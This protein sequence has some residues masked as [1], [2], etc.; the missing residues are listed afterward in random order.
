M[1]Y[2]KHSGIGTD[3]VITKKV[4]SVNSNGIIAFWS[5]VLRNFLFFEWNMLE[6][7]ASGMLLVVAIIKVIEPLFVSVYGTSKLL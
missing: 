5:S 3:M 4:V 6:N 1:S 2:E 7:D